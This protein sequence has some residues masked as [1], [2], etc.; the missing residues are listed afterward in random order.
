MNIDIRTDQDCRL[1]GV[2]AV[3][4]KPTTMP[5]IALT[6]DQA[7]RITIPDDAKILSFSLSKDV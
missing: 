1:T 7:K 2:Y 4:G 5:P 6:A 3:K